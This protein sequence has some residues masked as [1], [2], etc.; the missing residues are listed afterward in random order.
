MSFWRLIDIFQSTAPSQELTYGDKHR[1]CDKRISIHSSLA[2][3][4]HCYTTDD[5]MQVISIHSSLAG[6]DVLNNFEF[7]FSIPISIHSSLAGADG[8]IGVVVQLNGHF[9][10]Q[11]PRRS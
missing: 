11:L 1:G 8:D 5:Y 10:P 3:A 6:A 4:D 9:N 7:E 2:G